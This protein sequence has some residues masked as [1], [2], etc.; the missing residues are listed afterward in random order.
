MADGAAEVY[1]SASSSQ[2]PLSRKLKKI[3]ETRL[4]NDKE[5]IDALKALSTFFGENTLRARRNLR[6]DVERRS[7]DISEKF[8]TQFRDVKK[9]LDEIS[10]DVQAMNKCCQE[11]TKRLKN[12]KES[13]SELIVKTT[14]LQNERKQLELQSTLAESFLEKYQLK[15][16]E[17]KALRVSKDSI[18]NEDF[19]NALTRAKQI[20]QDCKMLLRSKQQTAGLEIMESMA[21]YQETAYE[22]LY[23]WTQEECRGMTGDIP[24]V[25][26]GLCRAIEA[27]QDRQ[28]L[29]R[30]TFDELATAR[31]TAVVRCFIDALTRGGSGGTPRPIELYSHDPVRY[32]GDIL[33]WLHQAVAGEKELLHSL[34]RRTKIADHKPMILEIL[35]HIMDG[36]CR[37]FKVRVE[38]VITSEAEAPTLFRLGNILKFYED[39]LLAIFESEDVTMLASIEEMRHLSHQMFFN[40]L[41]CY[42][43]KLAEKVDIPPPDLSPSQTVNTTMQLLKDVLSSHDS[44]ITPLKERQQDYGK[45]FSCLLD[46]LVQCCVLAASRLNSA[47]MATYMVNC[48]YQMQVTLAVY[49]FTDIKLE[50]LAVQNDAHT[51]TL[52]NEQA[53]FILS[54]SGLG[55]IYTPLKENE[56]KKISLTH[57]IDEQLVK[58]AMTKFD[59]YLSHPDSLNMPQL[60]LIRSTRIRD[61]IRKKAVDLIK[62]AFSAVYAV[63]TDPKSNYE[64]AEHL[65]GRTPEQINQLLS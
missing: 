24:D 35:N 32:V 5:L 40:S 57:G 49:E 44:A 16:H 6:G 39:T 54:R 45:I 47:D 12:S 51:E 29:L 10:D 50:M 55:N 58:T 19:F 36:V 2:N 9:K 1:T 64:N 23:R 8:E 61:T 18:V 46:P 41:S 52:T 14:K 27:L 38:Q 20:H 4:D 34:L 60:E 30:Y 63:I 3:L 56:N 28:V 17:V 53:S 37:P 48:L 13:T 11:M 31:R 62:M 25:S 42:G 65:I 15:Q 26:G 43:S 7:L 21:L 33:A 59:Q 22:K